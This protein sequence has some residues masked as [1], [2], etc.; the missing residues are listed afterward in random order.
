[1]EPLPYV[2][3]LAGAFAEPSRADHDQR[4]QSAEREPQ[5]PL[6]VEHQR[7]ADR[8][9]EE[10]GQ[11][12]GQ[13]RDDAALDGVEIG[14]EAR[15][16]VAARSAA[17]VGDREHLQPPEGG[18]AHVVAH[19]R[20]DARCHVL[21]EEIADDVDRDQ[22]D[23]AEDG[24]PD[25]RGIL[26][27]DGVDQHHQQ[28]RL[29]RLERHLRHAC[30][31][32]DGHLF[33]VGPYL[34]NRHREEPREA[35]ERR[36]GGLV[37]RL[38]AAVVTERRARGVRGVVGQAGASIPRRPRMLG[39]SPGVVMRMLLG[40]GRRLTLIGI[41]CHLSLTRSVGLRFVLG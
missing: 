6:D 22:P 23:E 15:E 29:D 24:C 35:R 37:A 1:M 12:E 18:H 19:G 26:R 33:P 21:E 3:R 20:A 32:H 16:E 40:H 38:P 7:H 39:A 9:A 17:M 11:R 28:H 31:H 30:Q 4:Q 34:A 8:D 14:A 10:T 2:A 25:A 5:P 41:V 36:V 27:H 13:F